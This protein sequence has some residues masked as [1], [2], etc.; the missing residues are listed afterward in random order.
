LRDISRLAAYYEFHAG[1][2]SASNYSGLA[3]FS[4]IPIFIAIWIFLNR[5]FATT[6]GLIFAGLMS[7]LLMIDLFRLFAPIKYY[8]TT[9]GV[10]CLLLEY[11][12]PTIAI[13]WL[14]K[15]E[16]GNA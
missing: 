12:L 8:T 7:T 13:L 5:K 6:F 9:L 14:R 10:L 3:V 15:L 2:W 1:K 16:K 4:G 11:L